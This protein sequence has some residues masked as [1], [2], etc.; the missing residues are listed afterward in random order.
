MHNPD[1]AG[2]VS[3]KAARART[4]VKTTPNKK[5]SK[6]LLKYFQNSIIEQSKALLPTKRTP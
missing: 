1:T 2:S 6:H 3:P 4:T 5:R